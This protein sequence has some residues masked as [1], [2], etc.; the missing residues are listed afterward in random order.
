MTSKDKNTYQR[1]Y[2]KDK[3]HCLI[4]FNQEQ[5]SFLSEK[6]KLAGKSFGRYLR[7]QA[8][9]KSKEEYIVPLDK[10]THEVIVL[11]VRYGTLLNQVA[12]V[13]NSTKT[14]TPEIIEQIRVNF[15]EMQTG[16]MKIYNAPVQVKILVRNTLIK[17]PS[18]AEEI[19]NV[20]TQLKL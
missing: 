12:F 6:A 20:L 19:R 5:H 8:L 10:Q 13:V 15:S 16:I 9:S 4:I 1:Q 3:K 7:E 14:V 11:L 17:T 2:R 18:Y